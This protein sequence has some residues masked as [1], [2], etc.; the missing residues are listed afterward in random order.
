MRRSLLLL[1]G[2]KN[3][4][5]FRYLILVIIVVSQSFLFLSVGRLPFFLLSFC[6]L[7]AERVQIMRTEG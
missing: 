4:W 2:R 1:H 6:H 5:L 7:Y 3:I